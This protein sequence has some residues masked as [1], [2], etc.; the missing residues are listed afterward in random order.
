[1]DAW[2]ASTPDPRLS[3]GDIVAP[4]PIGALAHPPTA[5]KKATFK[6][7][8]SGWAYDHGDSPERYVYR[9]DPGPVVVLSHSCEI[10]KNEKKRRILVAPIF[11]AT[12]LGEQWATV[13][14]GRRYSLMPLAG[15]PKIGDSYAD[16]RLIQSLDR[17]ILDG[18]EKIAGMTAEGL[19]AVQRHIVS[20]FIRDDHDPLRSEANSSRR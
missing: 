19:M 12:R 15:L 2:W 16:L 8:V 18:A 7:D 5:I 3:Q 1:M 17:R 14:D 13:Q 11:S 20:F 10:D 4:V 9:G 6:G